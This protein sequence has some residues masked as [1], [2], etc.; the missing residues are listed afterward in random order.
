MPNIYESVLEWLEEERQK[1]LEREEYMRWM[2]RFWDRRS[3]K[4]KLIQYLK[5]LVNSDV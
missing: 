4:P 3:A 1:E 5:K 2:R